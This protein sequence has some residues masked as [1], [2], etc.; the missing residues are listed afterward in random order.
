MRP[1]P[2][3]AAGVARGVPPGPTLLANT[4]RSKDPGVPA[5]SAST[6]VVSTTPAYRGEPATFSLLSGSSKF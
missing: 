5:S 3:P 2:R 6:R 4:L 1:R